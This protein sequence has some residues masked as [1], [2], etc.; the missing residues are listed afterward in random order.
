MNATA[1]RPAQRYRC[2]C[3]HRYQ[4]FA[5]GATGFY[6]LDDLATGAPRV[7]ARAVLPPGAAP[8]DAWACWR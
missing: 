2:R 7:M 4:V 1:A 3:E 6:E 8:Y 5:N